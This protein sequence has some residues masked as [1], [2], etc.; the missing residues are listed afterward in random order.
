MCGIAVDLQ[1]PDLDAVAD[2]LLSA[3]DCYGLDWREALT[4][5]V[6]AAMVARANLDAVKVADPQSYLWREWCRAMDA[7]IDRVV[8][9]RLAA[10]RREA[11]KTRTPFDVDLER[12]LEA[13]RRGSDNE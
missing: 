7:T 9:A 12:H 8:N 6:A 10:W 5:A 13:N 2:R 4:L 11:A 3:I 1:N